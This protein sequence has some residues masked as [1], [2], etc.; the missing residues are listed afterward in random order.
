MKYR[1]PAEEI[2]AAYL[3][4]AG[5]TVLAHNF[6]AGFAEIDIITRDPDGVMHFIE[7]RAWQK[8]LKHPLESIDSRKQERMRRAAYVY[9]QSIHA[10]EGS[11]SVSFDLALVSGTSVDMHL[12]IF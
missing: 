10:K 5:H 2:A 11:D 8:S 6:H 9:L 12:G 3:V 1:H 4:S 7:V